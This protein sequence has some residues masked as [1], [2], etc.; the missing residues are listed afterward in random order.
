[1]GGI[2]G[3]DGYIIRQ[4]LAYAIE[5]IAALP[6][7]YQEYSNLCDMLAILHASTGTSMASHLREGAAHHLFH[8]GSALKR[9]TAIDLV[10]E[11]KAS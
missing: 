11:N 10:L 7:E 8:E 3:R 6:S 4:A 1:M 2:T 9:N 5:V